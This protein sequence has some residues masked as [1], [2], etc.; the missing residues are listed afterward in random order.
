M[1][2]RNRRFILRLVYDDPYNV[3]LYESVDKN[4]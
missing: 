4:L 3:Y 1:Q 2:S